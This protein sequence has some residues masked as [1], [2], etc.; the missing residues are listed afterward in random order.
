MIQKVNISFFR[1]NSRTNKL[2]MA[3]VYCR[4][5]NVV[6]SSHAKAIVLTTLC[7]EFFRNNEELKFESPEA[8]MKA[9]G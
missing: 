7:R 5:R 1:Y 6:Q 9:F 8:F 2:G 3:P 4:E